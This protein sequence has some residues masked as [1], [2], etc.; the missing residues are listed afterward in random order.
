MQHSSFTDWGTKTVSNIQASTQRQSEG[1]RNRGLPLA[2]K[3]SEK[4][5]LETQY[6]LLTSATLP[7]Q[8]S[9]TQT[10]I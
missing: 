1:V 3:D 9:Y 8:Q 7:L 5:H 2:L 4:I 6:T 10:S